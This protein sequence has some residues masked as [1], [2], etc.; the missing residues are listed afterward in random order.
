MAERSTNLIAEFN[1]NG[2]ARGWYMAVKT[3]FRDAL[4]IR[5]TNRIIGGQT[6]QIWTQ[7][8]EFYFKTG[9]TLHNSRQIYSAGSKFETEGQLIT[10]QVSSALPANGGTNYPG[11]VNFTIYLQYSMI[12]SRSCTQ[13]EFVKLLKNGH[14]ISSDGDIINLQALPGR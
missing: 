2:F 10:V 3:C 13:A 12:M 7:G 11:Q 8:N 5:L 1:K 14:C 9:D 4:D 6:Q